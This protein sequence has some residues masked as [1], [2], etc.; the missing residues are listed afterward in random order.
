MRVGFQAIAFTVLAA[1]LPACGNAGE[2]AH[3][4]EEAPAAAA[5]DPHH[6]ALPE[7]V[8]R[9]VD[10]PVLDP[11][12]ERRRQ[13]VER[14]LAERYRGLGWQIAETTQTYTGDIID[15]LDPASVPGS[16]AE[17]PPG[18]SPEELRPPPGAELQVTELDLYP[19]LR[20]PAGTIA[21][22][23][24]SFSGYVRGETTATSI[25]DFS[26]HHH[27]PGQPLGQTRLYGG[28]VAPQANKGLVSWINDFS[29]TVE[30]GTFS[31]IEMATVC[32]GSNSNTTMILAPCST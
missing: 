6:S 11:D 30:A 8:V 13:E 19:E 9:R 1:L 32:P 20:G 10:R 7:P 16:D 24:P 4:G 23:R 28:Y 22:V 17:P 12:Q 25:E 31:L 5:A 29:E 18:P 2:D 15:W 14:Y 27:V 3:P 26:E 21:M